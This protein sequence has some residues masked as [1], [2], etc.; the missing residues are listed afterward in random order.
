MKAN[1]QIK[2]NDHLCGYCQSYLDRIEPERLTLS[3]SM[4]SKHA[5]V[6]DG[7]CTGTCNI[8]SIDVKHYLAQ[9]AHDSCQVKKY[10]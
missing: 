8:W 6:K 7:G 9:Q 10:A 3:K 4:K 2:S 1:V 5:L